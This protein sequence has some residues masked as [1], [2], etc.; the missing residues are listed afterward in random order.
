[1]AWYRQGTNRYLGHCWLSSIS[2]YGVNL[3][4][5]ACCAMGT[6]HWRHNELDGVSDHQPHDCLLTC[7]FRHRS[8]KTS[9][10]RVTGLCEGNSPGPANCPHKRPVTR[11]T[12]PFDDVIMRIHSTVNKSC[13]IVCMLWNLVSDFMPWKCIIKHITVQYR[14]KHDHFLPDLK[15]NTHNN[16]SFCVLWNCIKKIKYISGFIL[17]INIG[18]F[19]G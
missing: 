14:Y 6:L 18:T 17:S 16:S 5:W 10:L 11:K 13:Y 4:Q 2:P 3:P 7:L 9:K 12:F 19:F 15:I 8:K 1:M